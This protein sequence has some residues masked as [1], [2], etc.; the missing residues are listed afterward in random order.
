[1][2]LRLHAHESLLYIFAKEWTTH[3]LPWRH[4]LRL[5][6]LR[7]RFS[8][9]QII[10]KEWIINAFREAILH[11]NKFSAKEGNGTALNKIIY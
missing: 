3:D 11:E 5:P 8:L 9:L 2:L 1:M 10:T 6:K 7:S 4:F